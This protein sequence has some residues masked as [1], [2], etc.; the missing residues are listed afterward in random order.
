MGEACGVWLSKTKKRY[1]PTLHHLEHNVNLM[2]TSRAPSKSLLAQTPTTMVGLCSHPTA[3]HLVQA[4]LTSPHASIIHKRKI[5]NLLAGHFAQLAISPS[6]SHLVDACWNA[7]QGMNNYWKGIAQELV[8]READVRASLFGRIVWR[9][10]AMDTFKTRRGDWV[11]LGKCEEGA[12][13]CY[14]GFTGTAPGSSL[15]LANEGVKKSAIQVRLPLNNYYYLCNSSIFPTQFY[16]HPTD[17]ELRRC[18]SVML[19]SCVPEPQFGRSHPILPIPLTCSL[20]SFSQFLP[21]PSAH[22]ANVHRYHIHMR[23][24]LK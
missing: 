22:H 9:N 16:L 3:S 8:A 13:E 10:W 11:K 4:S 14:P 12:G 23:H 24:R 20:N 7:A 18:A 19:V 17:A 1:F 2:L 15:V 6:G 21:W 5:F